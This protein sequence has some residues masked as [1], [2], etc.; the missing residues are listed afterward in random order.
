MSIGRI[1]PSLAVEGPPPARCSRHIW[2]RCSSPPYVRD[3]SR[4]WTPSRLTRESECARL[5]RG[6]AASYCAYHTLFTGP[7]PHRGSLRQT[8]GSLV[9]GNGPE[10]RGTG[11]GY[12]AAVD[13]I[14]AGSV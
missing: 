14:S 7:Q 3:E 5:S 1:G 8:Q 10:P 6:T 13:A 12:G 4:R 2:R 11:R 9:C